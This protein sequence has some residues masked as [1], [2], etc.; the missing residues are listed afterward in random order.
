MYLAAAIERD[1][2]RYP[3]VGT[4][5]MVVQHTSHPQAHGYVEARVEKANPFLSVGI[6]LRGHEFHHS[7]IVNQV[8]TIDTALMLVRGVGVR[9]GRDGI[10]VGNVFATYTH[11]FAPGTP[12]WA[13]ALVRVA[14]ELGRRGRNDSDDAD[15]D[16]DDAK[17]WSKD[18]EWSKDHSRRRTQWRA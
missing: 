10:V 3:M 18:Q 11:F 4:L 12:E 16:A 5:P 6:R 9:S 14:R 1:G 2:V 15:D 17:E 8:A 13:P 7:R